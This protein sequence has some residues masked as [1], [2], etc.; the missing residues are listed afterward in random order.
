MLFVC[1]VEYFNN[2][3]RDPQRPQLPEHPSSK[4][5]TGSQRAPA[6]EHAYAPPVSFHG[7][8]P[9][10]PPVSYRPA[11]YAGEN[12]FSLHF[13]CF[14]D[15]CWLGIR[16]GIRPIKNRVVRCW[17]GSMAWSDVRWCHYHSLSLASVKSRLVF[18][19]HWGSPAKRAVKRVCR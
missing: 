16:K 17:H 9:P 3:L 14:C 2:Y 6:R 19:A 10:P 5:S 15:T 7:P 4:P 13:Q 1:K 11:P 8:L 12:L 18:L